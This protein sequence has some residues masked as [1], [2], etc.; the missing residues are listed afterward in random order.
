[1]RVPARPPLVAGRDLIWQ[2]LKVQ[3]SMAVCQP[4]ITQQAVLYGVRHL[5]DWVLA[6]NRLMQRRHDLFRQAFAGPLGRAENRTLPDLRR[7]EALVLLP[8]VILMFVVGILPNLVLSPTDATVHQLLNR[9]EERSVVMDTDT[10]TVPAPTTSTWLD[11][12]Q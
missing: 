6:K 7:P 9:M 10:G 4:C 2:A 12:T 5:D 8:L 1:M 3:D 11:G